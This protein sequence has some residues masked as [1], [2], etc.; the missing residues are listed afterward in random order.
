MHDQLLT[1]YTLHNNLNS[2][3]VHVYMY[4]YIQYIYMYMHAHV[5]VHAL[6][7]AQPFL[8]DSQC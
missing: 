3:D 6:F 1:Y 5:H 4:M 8:T 2:L 7:W